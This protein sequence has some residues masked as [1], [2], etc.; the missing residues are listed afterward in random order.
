MDKQ[1]H[2]YELLKDF[3]TAMLVTHAAD[4]DMHV[5]PMAVAELEPDAEAYFMTSIDSPKVADLEA[6]PNVT[7]TFQSARQFA[8]VYGEARIV[9]DQALIDRLWKDA[10]Q[11]WFP[12]GKTDPAL[13]LLHFTPKHGEYW[14]NAGMQ[15]V[16]YAFKAIG[17]YVKGETPKADAKQHGKV[18]L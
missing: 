5:R 9:R 2:L 4:G 7:L 15:G 3:D 11:V 16:K 1:Q 12:K 8:S 14:D 13:G 17:A 6:H 18:D 10:W